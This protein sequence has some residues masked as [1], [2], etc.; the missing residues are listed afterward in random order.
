MGLGGG[1]LM[2]LGVSFGLF[3]VL[4]LLLVLFLVLVNSTFNTSPSL[5]P[6]PTF[7]PNP[8]IKSSPNPNPSSVVAPY[9]DG[10]GD[11]SVRLTDDQYLFKAGKPTVIHMYFGSIDFDFCLLSFVLHLLYTVFGLGSFVFVFVFA[12]GL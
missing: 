1:G 12:F 8:Y 7:D 10:I 4:D 5:N 3:I 11:R 9:R 6:N 2:L